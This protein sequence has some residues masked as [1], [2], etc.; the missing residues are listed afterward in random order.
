[1]VGNPKI[2]NTIAENAI[3]KHREELT[4]KQRL[5][6]IGRYPFNI[7]DLYF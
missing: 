5:K 1:M 2:I 4:C 7:N 3:I 6:K